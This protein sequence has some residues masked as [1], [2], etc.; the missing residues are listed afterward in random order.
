MSCSPES[1]PSRVSP[2]EGMSERVEPG[3][4]GRPKGV[5]QERVSWTPCVSE[6][7]KGLDQFCRAIL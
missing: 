5:L 1:S 2:R 3:Q 6:Y 7:K 4:Y